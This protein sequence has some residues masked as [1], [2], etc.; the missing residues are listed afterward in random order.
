MLWLSK[1]PQKPASERPDPN[2]GRNRARLVIVVFGLC[3]LTIGARIV[4][5]TALGP[6]SDP[7]RTAS[8]STGQILR[9]DIVD[10]TGLVMATDLRMSSLFANPR[11]I[12][13]VDEAIEGIQKVLP[14]ENGDELRRRLSAKKGFVWLKRDLSP[15]IRA[16]LHDLGV[17]GLGFRNETKRIYPMGSLA[18]HVLGFVDVDSRGLAGVE[19]YLDGPGALYKASLAD[20]K[21]NASA[22]VVL[23]IDA[24]AQYAL[25]EELSNAVE[26]FKAKGALG[27]V[28]D[29]ETGEVVAAASLPDFNPNDPKDALMK[30]RIN[31]F[32]GGV[33][34]LGSVFKSVTFAMALD[35]GTANLN[36]RF[37]ARY[38][39]HVGGST[40][41]DF[42][43]QRRVLTLPEVFTYSSNIGTAKM[44]LGVGLKGHQAFLKK[45]GFFDR[46]RTEVS[47]AA[48]PLVPKKWR[49]VSTMT[50]SFGHGLSVQPLQLVSAGAA[51]VN[52]GRLIK[53]T[54]FKRDPS[55]VADVSKQVI[56][57]ETSRK[58]RYLFRL[59]VTKGTAGKAKVE[60]YAVG[61][62]TGT[63]EK[64]IRGRYSK[65]HRFNSFLGAFP[66]D[67]PRY[68]IIVSIDEPQAVKGTYG[69]ATSGWNAVPTAG[70]VI[71]RL[72]P[73]L[74]ILPRTSPVTADSVL[75]NMAGG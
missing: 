36:S 20:P 18:A 30:D 67:M 25:I 51:L 26:H 32:S 47:E 56:R 33:F 16:K 23:S 35:A 52:G 58:M 54:F 44:A 40:I 17:P 10:R 57:P 55:V 27:V 7:I 12:L 37:D 15:R 28:L 19:K 46:L 63:A 42:H 66:M 34:E 45:L 3:F 5:L 29:V 13:D 39:I 2:R 14:N 11:K 65:Q 53:P 72:A 59:N 8:V 75:N 60:G 43:P 50:V 69:Y 64:V 48:A 70:K 4:Q 62:K 41:S 24:R 22:P 73:I 1:K 6:N 61:G 74:G 71:K 21:K 49:R 68:A 38:P 9:P 31:R